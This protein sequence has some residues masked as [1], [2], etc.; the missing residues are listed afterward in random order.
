MKKLNFILI[1]LVMLSIFAV[2]VSAATYITTYW[3][4]NNADTLTIGLDENPEFDLIISS[5]SNEIYYG[6]DIYKD[7]N[8]EYELL[9]ENVIEETVANWNLDTTLTL[10]TSN[11]ELGNYLVFIFSNYGEAYEELYLTISKITLKK[12]GTVV[13]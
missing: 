1:G 9:E 3:T 12:T 6:F 8:G 13:P 7:V 2:N 10:N 4:G 11:Y 5:T